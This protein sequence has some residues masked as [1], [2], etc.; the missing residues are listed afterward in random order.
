MTVTLKL[1]LYVLKIDV[2]LGSSVSKVTLM[3]DEKVLLKSSKGT[4]KVCEIL[5][6]F[7]FSLVSWN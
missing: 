5:L 6:S 3:N 4:K 2:L 7:C 1:W